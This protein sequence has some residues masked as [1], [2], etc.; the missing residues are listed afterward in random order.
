[1]KPKKD[2]K[3]GRDSSYEH[4]EGEVIA[5]VPLQ[6]PSEN[7]LVLEH[8]RK[9][10]SI[11]A[12]GLL[13]VILLIISASLAFSLL[14]RIDIVVECPSV[15]RPTSHKTKIHSDRDGYVEGIFIKE[16]EP[17]NASDPLY[18]IKSGEVTSLHSKI[19]GLTQSIPLKTEYYDTKI[20]SMT[21]QLSY[22]EK[23]MENSLKTRRLKLDQN[24]MTLASIAVDVAYWQEQKKGLAVE[25]ANIKMLYEKKLYS[26]PLFN[27]VKSRLEQARAEMEKLDKKREIALD[28]NLI[29]EAEVQ[30]IKDDHTN[31]KA[32]L[33]NELKNCRIERDT[34]V[35]AL[36]KELD[37]TKNLLALKKNGSKRDGAQGRGDSDI[38]RANKA[39][40][41]F[42]IFVKNRG[43]YVR[44]SDLLLTIIPENSPLY[45]DIE[46]ANKD[47]GFISEKMKIRYKIDAFP[48]I[49]YGV[50]RGE[51][52]SVSPSAVNDSSSGPTYRIKGSI[53]EPFFTI[54]EKKYKVKAGMTATAELITKNKSIFSV[55][56]DKLMGDN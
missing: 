54:K 3:P 48:H 13:Y 17:V 52:I 36:Q 40:T 34:T 11:F 21:E 37:L 32:T 53:I 23:K 28:E 1:M 41:I 24:Q 8:L 31:K 6:S 51:V 42:E 10:P 33:E 19:D 50:L 45:M 38:I 9:M 26:Y 16:G 39:G 46:V 2:I 43:E 29:I 55:M 14:C 22:L 35:K 15:A 20:F 25:F 18:V 47:I 5:V 30:E 49:D 7:F 27:A 44:E 12:R 56:F 4:E